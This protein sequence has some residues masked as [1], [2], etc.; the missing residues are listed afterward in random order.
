MALRALVTKLDGI[1]ERAILWANLA[2]ACLIGIAHGGAL[3]LTYAKPGPEADS[4]RQLAS[5]SLPIA[6]VVLVTSVAALIQAPFRHTVLALHGALFAAAAVVTV[7]WALSILVSGIPEG[8]FVWSPG[9]MSAL[10]AYA[11]F[12][13]SRYSL[14]LR[15][16]NRALVFYAPLLALVVSIPI[17]VAVFV[18]TINEVAK[19][20]G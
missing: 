8:K 7:V 6:G 18:K 19:G 11:F 10:V 1:P 13:G 12:V 5:I 2:L 14:P 16:R 20:F 3:A 4:I 9:M 15:F 17:D